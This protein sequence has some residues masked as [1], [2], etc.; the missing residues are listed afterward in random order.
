AVKPKAT[1]P[2]SASPLPGSKLV[3]FLRR[4]LDLERKDFFQGWFNTFTPDTPAN[5]DL[6]YVAR[7]EIKQS[8]TAGAPEYD[9]LLELSYLPSRDITQMSVLES[10]VRSLQASVGKWI[11]E[12]SLCLVVMSEYL[13]L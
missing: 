9:A 10:E 11:D 13:L 7:S 4:D 8:L 6:R 12:G 5:S 3:A 2:D 1:R